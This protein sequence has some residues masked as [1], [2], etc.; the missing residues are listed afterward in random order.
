MFDWLV[1]VLSQNPIFQ[2]YGRR[3]Q[4]H[5]KYQLGCFLVRYGAIGSD[6]LGNAQ[7]LS[8]GFGTVFLHCHR[9]CHALCKL[10]STRVGWPTPG[11]KLTIKTHIKDVSGFYQCLGAGNGSLVNFDDSD[12]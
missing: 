8:I 5:I 6:T 10:C 9:A 12:P 7:K 4:H 2:S 3:P 1:G 11:R